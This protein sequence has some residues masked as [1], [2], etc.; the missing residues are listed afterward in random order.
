[1]NGATA[2]F[3]YGSDGRS[4]KYF[5]IDQ[6]GP[7]SVMF[8]ETSTAYGGNVRSPWVEEDWGDGSS[9]P[10][11]GLNNRHDKG[12]NLVLIDTSVRWHTAKQYE[13]YVF[14]VRFRPG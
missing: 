3:P 10:D 9:S 7:T 1:M 12:A 11:Q 14:S 4:Y 5:R 13:D 2:E 6:Y 8:W